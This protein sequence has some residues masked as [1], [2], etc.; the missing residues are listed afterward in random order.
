MKIKLS[1]EQSLQLRNF[2]EKCEDAEAL[3]AKE[4]VVD[5]YDIET[6][7]SLDLVFL[8]SGVAIDGAAE[9]KYD[10][11]MDGWYMGDPL[12]QPEQVMQALEAAGAFEA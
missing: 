3:S 11:E 5:L 6:P 9:L 2:L 8:K 7:V 1:G 10:D 12:E 4:Y